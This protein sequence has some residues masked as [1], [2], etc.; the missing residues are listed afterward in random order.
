MALTTDFVAAVRRQGSIPSS[1]SSTDILAEGDLAI[2]TDFIPLLESLKQNYFVR[3]VT[4]S[5]D[6]RGRIPLPARA[7]GAS[8]RSVQLAVGNGWMPLPQR[9]LADDDFISAAAL[10][11]AFALDAG[12]IILLPSGSSGTLRLRYAARPGKMCLDTDASLAKA[13][14]AVAAPGATTTAITAAFTGSLA[15]CDIVSSGPAHQQKAIGAALGGVQPNLTVTNTDLLEQPVV[16]DYVALADRSPFVPLPE[17]LFG[18]LVHTVAANILLAR[19]YLEEAG[20]QAELA[21]KAVARARLYLMPRIEGNPKI[22]GGGLRRALGGGFRGR[23][24]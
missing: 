17:E 20:A 4:A 23:R 19:A 13:L 21:E 7:A 24:W 10:P 1:M 18:A 9:D 12:S 14:T 11:Y 15:S 3:E 22:V 5:P 8:L 6:A 2:Q 16:G